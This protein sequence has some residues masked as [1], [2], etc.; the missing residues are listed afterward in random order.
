MKLSELEKRSLAPDR[1]VMVPGLG[2]GFVR[3]LDQARNEA[4]VE[5]VWAG[6]RKIV[7]IGQDQI[8]AVIHGP[9][10]PAPER[11]YRGFQRQRWH[12]DE[13]ARAAS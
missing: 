3:S 4:T 9:P 12:H 7:T 13:D 10:P 2:F 8:G 1:N 6:P 11:D 5:I